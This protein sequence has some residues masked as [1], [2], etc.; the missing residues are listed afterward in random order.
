MGPAAGGTATRMTTAFGGAAR[1]RA[2]ISAFFRLGFP[3]NLLQETATNYKAMSYFYFHFSGTVIFFTICVISILSLIDVTC[4]LNGKRGKQ[5]T[6][7]GWP[8]TTKAVPPSAPDGG[9]QLGQGFAGVATELRTRSL[10]WRRHWLRLWKEAGEFESFS[11][12]VLVE[13]LF[14][15]LAPGARFGRSHR[16]MD[17]VR[18]ARFRAMERRWYASP[19]W[20][21]ALIRH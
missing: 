6:M 15:F 12:A 17:K 8:Q 16:G 5:A 19:G 21:G 3:R 1:L 10:A 14:S 20:R 11:S 7:V 13:Q 9:G 18:A 2:V 4:S